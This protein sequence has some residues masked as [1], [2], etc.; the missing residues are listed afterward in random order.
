VGL[1]FRLLSLEMQYDAQ[2]CAHWKMMVLAPPS[3]LKP[4]KVQASGA[5]V[6]GIGYRM[7]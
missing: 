1:N 7:G 3:A 5:N 2:R 6:A 4:T